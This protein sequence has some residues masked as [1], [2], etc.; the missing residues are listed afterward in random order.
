[1][2]LVL[3]AV[4]SH[5]HYR[6]ILAS[7][8]DEYYERPAAPAGFWRESPQVL[9]GRDLR[10]GGTWLG[11]TTEGRIGVITNYRD[12]SSS[13]PSGRSRGDL[14]VDFL[15]GEADPSEYLERLARVSHRYPGFNLIVGIEDE[16]YWYSN[17]GREAEKLEPGVH[18]LSNHLLNTPWP[19]VRRG[20]RAL[21]EVISRGEPM[22][23]AV[24]DILSERSIPRDAELPDTGVGIQWERILAPPFI[25]S[26]TY[27][28]RS[29]SVVLI[30]WSGN[31]RF[32]ERHFEP[33]S[34]RFKVTDQAF[35]LRS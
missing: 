33:R 9:A 31:L 3:L 24:F 18:G 4:R 1:M 2:C 20:K 25:V 16:L 22:P 12:P 21:A 19:K 26:P 30:D 11:V 34:D 8:R 17:R 35:C 6:L 23:Q 14:V 10:D 27:G 15:R 28:T 29:S 32:I 5:P 13:M 7:N